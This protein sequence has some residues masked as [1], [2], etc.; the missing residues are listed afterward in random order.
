MLTGQDLIKY[1]K[2]NL[3][4]N[5]SQLAKGAGYV[6]TE[7]DGKTVVLVQAFYDALLEAQGMPL[8]KGPVRGRPAAN[9]V[10]VQKN[11]IVVLGKRYT[12]DFGVQP[13]D[14]LEIALEDDSIRLVPTAA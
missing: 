10:S 5:K 13:G 7:A 11:G 6:R 12:K 8:R 9:Q 4:L 1:V 3:S 14:V 2:S